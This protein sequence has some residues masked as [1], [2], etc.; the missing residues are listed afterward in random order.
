MRTLHC[1]MWFTSWITTMHTSI[2]RYSIIKTS[3]SLLLFS[4]LCIPCG[5]NVRCGSMQFSLQVLIHAGIDRGARTRC[6]LEFYRLHACLCIFW[7]QLFSAKLANLRHCTAYR[8]GTWV[9]WLSWWLHVRIIGGIWISSL[10]MWSPYV[11]FAASV[12]SDHAE[13]YKGG[14]RTPEAWR[15]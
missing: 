2:A 4:Q 3:S 14:S 10:H 8:V 11:E 13:V 15:S 6:L 9:P 5:L 1:L 7:R 12:T